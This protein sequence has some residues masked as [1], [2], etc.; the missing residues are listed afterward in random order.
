MLTKE[1]RAAI[2]ALIL[3]WDSFV[4]L[5]TEHPNDAT[6]FRSHIHALQEKILARPAR[7]WINEEITR[8]YK[9]KYGR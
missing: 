7:R 4:E 8:E 3:A 1:E 9:E 6:E 2:D 5:P